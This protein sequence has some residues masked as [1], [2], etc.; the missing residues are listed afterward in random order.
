[1]K[2]KLDENLG[3]SVAELFRQ[4]GHEV[5]GK[6]LVGQNE[7][8]RAPK[9]EVASGESALTRARTSS[10]PSLCSGQALSHGRGKTLL[11]LPPP[12]PRPRRWSVKDAPAEIDR[13]ELSD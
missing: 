8:W 3:R 6:W 10:T 13:D 5:S 11:I 1:M 2:L 9:R 7:Q 4:A 12:R